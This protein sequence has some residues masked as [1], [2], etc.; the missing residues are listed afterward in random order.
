MIA[1]YFYVP[2]YLCIVLVRNVKLQQDHNYIAMVAL[3]QLDDIC[4]KICN[5]SIT[6]SSLDI[7]KEKRAQLRKLCDAV[8]SGSE[9]LC[10]S[11]SEVEPHL[12]KCVNLQTK[13]ANYRDCISTLLGL[14]RNISD[15]MFLCRIII[16]M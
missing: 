16:R 2:F 12:V 8:N 6:L 10:M 13:F 7:V 15:G 11:Y 3:S 14:C 1:K 4:K 9:N 5:K